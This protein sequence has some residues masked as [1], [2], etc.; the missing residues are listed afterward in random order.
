MAWLIGSPTDEIHQLLGPPRRLL[1]RGGPRRSSVGEPPC[2]RLLLLGAGGG[3][4]RP[5]AEP[6]E[7]AQAHRVAQLATLQQGL[8]R[9]GGVIEQGIQDCVA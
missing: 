2:R 1:L 8:A 4:H 9:S 3:L 5:D 6:A 7:V